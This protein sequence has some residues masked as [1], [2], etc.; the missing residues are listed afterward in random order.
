MRNAGLDEAQAGIKIAGRNINNLSY[1]DDITLMAESKEE[2]KSLL[3]NVKEES[4]KVGLKLNIQKTKIMASGPITSWQIGR[5]TLETVIDFILG[6][7]KIT[8]DGNCSHEIK[9]HLLLG[10]KVMTNLDSILKSRD[11]TL[12]TKFCL[13]IAMV[14]LAVMYGCES[15]SINK[16]E[17]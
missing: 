14:F 16:A 1:S 6:G 4:E 13:V 10:R 5:E 11:I 15:W 8:A 9:R 12:P 7:S 3:M 2:L 17:H